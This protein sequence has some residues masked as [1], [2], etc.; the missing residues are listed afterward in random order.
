MKFNG[1]NVRISESAKI[2]SNVRI[3]DGTVIY[4]HVEIG[5][6]SVIADNCIIGE[7]IAA[8]YKEKDYINPKTVVGCNALI[9][10]GTIIYAGVSIGSH[11][12][13]GHRVTVRES[14][15]IGNYCSLGTGTD[16]QGYLS[17]GDHCRLHSQVHVCQNSKLGNFVFIYPNVVLANDTHPPSETVS[18]PTVGDHTQ[19]GI[20][21]SIVGGISIGDNCLVGAHSLVLTNFESFSQIIGTPAKRRGDVREIMGTDGQPL[22]PWRHRFKRGMPWSESRDKG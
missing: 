12:E 4:D 3:G 18:G 15:H 8:Y 1:Y 9:R 2:G 7:P 17:M 11:F 14:S 6:D 20:Q 13:T 22:Y 5:D 21:S 19:V 10:S 16:L